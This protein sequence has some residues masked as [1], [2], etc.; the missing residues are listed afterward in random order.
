MD[1]HTV[2]NTVHP[3]T[4]SNV[5]V[6]TLVPLPRSWHSSLATLY[7]DPRHDG[8]CWPHAAAHPRTL[9]FDVP[10]KIFP[11]RKSTFTN[12]NDTLHIAM[13]KQFITHS[14][15]SIFLDFIRKYKS[16]YPCIAVWS[17]WITLQLV[18][19]AIA[20]AIYMKDNNFI[21]WTTI[22]HS[23]LGHTFVRTHTMTVVLNI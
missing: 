1:N 7:R 11:L 17:L 6:R 9:L 19:I 15:T 20:M 10:C 21:I 5:G 4:A 2:M 12:C 8:L 23:P 18:Q 14:T 13:Q 22:V 16:S 3:A